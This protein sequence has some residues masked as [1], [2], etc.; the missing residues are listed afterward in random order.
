MLSPASQQIGLAIGAGDGVGPE[1]VAVRVNARR[2]AA[3]TRQDHQPIW[4]TGHARLDCRRTLAGPAGYHPGQ[5]EIVVVRW[6]CQ[7]RTT[8]NRRVRPSP[9]PCPATTALTYG[10]C[11]HDDDV[12]KVIGRHH[13]PLP[14]IGRWTP[15]TN[16]LVEPVGA[17]P[18]PGSPASA[19]APAADPA[20]RRPARRAVD[21]AVVRGDELSDAKAAG[22]AQEGSRR[23]EGPDR[24][25]QRAAGRPRRRRSPDRRASCEGINADLAAVKTKIT[26]MQSQ[27]QRRQ[28]RLRRPR[29]PARRHDAELQ[30]VSG[31]EE[32]A[33]RVELTER[34]RPARRP[35]AQ[36]LR[37]RPHLARSRRS[38]PAGRSPTCSPR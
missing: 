34:K 26:K 8:T 29:R 10:A 3:S 2:L 17:R 32:S 28:G 7:S 16:R 20:R 25:D 9:A 18:K 33:K 38:C 23:A 11:S 30:R 31:A 37:H 36:R 15:R 19:H 22:A 21:T 6:Q 5:P 1:I 24:R 27:D 12:A 14:R 35:R 13:D 4:C